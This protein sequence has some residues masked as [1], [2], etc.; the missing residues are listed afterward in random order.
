MKEKP[1][2]RYCE[3]P[4]SRSKQKPDSFGSE[5]YPVA[6]AIWPGT[7]RAAIARTTNQRGAMLSGLRPHMVRRP[8]IPKGET[9]MLTENYGLAHLD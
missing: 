5:L 1:D 8:A 2:V 4:E 7:F 3:Y 9:S 6:L